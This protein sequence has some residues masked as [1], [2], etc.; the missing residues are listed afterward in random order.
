M[1]S[2]AKTAL[3]IAALVALAFGA[4]TVLSGGRALFGSAAAQAAVGDAVPFVLWF[5]FVAGF[6]YIAAGVALILRRAARLSLG[7][8]PG[9]HPS[10]PCRLWSARASGRRL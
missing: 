8:D 1:A 6:A 10:C 3:W 9:R 7:L 2:R 4:L 5:D